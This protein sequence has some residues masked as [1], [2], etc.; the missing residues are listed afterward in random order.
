MSSLY[1]K[2]VITSLLVSSLSANDNALLNESLENLLNTDIQSKAQV[3]TR[4]KAKDSLHSNA[5]VDVIT[6]KQIQNSGVTTLTDL[7]S[8]YVADFTSHR[9]SLA[10][11]VDHIVQYTLRGMQADQILVLLNSKRYHPSSLVSTSQGTS[12]VDLNSIPLEAINRVEIL[13]DGAAAQYGSD[14]IT[15]VINI[16]LKSK[17]EST[18]TLHGGMRK[19][20]D[21]EETQADSFVN[22]PLEYDGFINFTISANHKNSTNRAGKDSRVTPSRVT[23]HFGLPDSKALQ[24]AMN[25]EV[26]SKNNTI[27]YSNIITNYKES[28]ASTFFRTPDA[29]RAIYPEGFLP[30]LKD[31]ILDYSL[32]FG[33]EGNFIDGTH[34]DM[35]NVYGY[36]S[37]DFSL[38]NS[39]NYDLN[40]SSP[41]SFDNGKLATKQN[42]TNIDVKKTVDKLIVSGG[43][44]YRYEDY[45]IKSGDEASYYGTGSQGFP[46]YQPSNEVDQSR[47]SYAAYI[48]TIFNISENFSTDL[49]LRYENFSDFGDTTNYKAATKYQLTPKLLLRA[50]TSTGFRAPSMSQ[51]S[52]SYTSSSLSSGVLRKKGIFQPNHPV[53]KSLGAKKLQAEK[54]THY[55]LGFVYEPNKNSYLM[56]DS[57][58]VHVKERILLSQKLSASTPEQIAIFNQYNVS[59]V[60]YFTNIGDITTSGIDIKYNSLYTFK[61]DSSLDTTL[62]FNYSKNKVDNKNALSTSKIVTIEEGMPK[63]SVKLLNVY[64]ISD[65]TVGVNINYYGTYKNTI[66]SSK[67]FSFDS[68]VTTDLN[69]NYNYKKNIDFSIGGFNIFDVHPSKW[70]RSNQFFGS[71]GIMPYSYRSPVNYSGAYYYLAIKYRF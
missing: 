58:L 63:E 70:D 52:Y 41:T 65:T 40:A 48:D 18:L 55:S 27:F 38:R 9:T 21:G 30:M 51:N 68:L 46:G 22:I 12:F 1:K 31:T 24:M 45:S 32:A 25:S 3:G 20:G 10:D 69:I 13:R 14:A 44:E 64:K 57:F 47:E 49:A 61:N 2:V 26:V 5:P 59:G 54:S 19:E 42:T 37:S 7:L 11:G 16:I 36:N 8:Y 15:G 4:G 39:M 28:E 50:T 71:D 66:G 53:S 62:W 23:M 29:S 35:S 67:V 60:Q 43:L 56:V 17:D 6:L 33:A 34:W